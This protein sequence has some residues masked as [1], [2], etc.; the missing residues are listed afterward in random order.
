[1]VAIVINVYTKQGLKKI[2]EGQHQW[3]E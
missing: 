3:A 2:I 1:M